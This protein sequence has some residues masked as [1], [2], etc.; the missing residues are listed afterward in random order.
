M[1]DLTQ[2]AELLREQLGLRLPAELRADLRLV[3][4]LGMDSLHLAELFEVLHWDLGLDVDDP[5]A[6][7]TMGDIVAVINESEAGAATSRPGSG[8]S[9]R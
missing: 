8:V 7:Q 4:D 3:E 1:T 5:P 2:L 6:L 9:E